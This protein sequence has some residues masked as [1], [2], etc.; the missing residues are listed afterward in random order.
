MI[1][2]LS[3][4][5]LMLIAALGSALLLGGAFV[6]QAFGYAPCKLCLWQRWPHA[7]AIL[8]GVIAVFR[9]LRAVAWL[10]AGAALLTAGFGIYHTGVE[11]GWW[12][13]PSSC[14]GNGAG[15]GG[16]SGA[17]LLSTDGP[18]NIVMCDEV[19]WAFAGL[20]MASWNAVLSLVLAL[21]W[22]RA[23]TRPARRPG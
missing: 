19:A 13:G 2:S 6:F 9:P 16:L 8:L 10:G 12:E 11:R 7:A 15:V 23:A 21:I 1:S 14:T 18:S 22:V 20:S 4:R 5:R 17:D 3:P